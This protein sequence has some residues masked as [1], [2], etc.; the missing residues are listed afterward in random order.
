MGRGANVG[1]ILHKLNRTVV[2]VL[3]VYCLLFYASVF[4]VVRSCLNISWNRHY[5]S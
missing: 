2:L 3:L 5:S 1:T 4:H